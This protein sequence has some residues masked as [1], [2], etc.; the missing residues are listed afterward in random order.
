LT[1]SGGEAALECLEF[2]SDLVYEIERLL[3]NIVAMVNLTGEH[4]CMGSTDKLPFNASSNCIG[5]AEQVPNGR[6]TSDRTLVGTALKERLLVLVAHQ[7]DEMSCAG[8][9]QRS[10]DRIIAYATDGAPPD[11]YF[12]ASHGSRE[13]YAGVRRSEALDAT[14]KIGVSKLEFLDFADQLLYCALDAAFRAVSDIVQQYKPDAVLVPA[15]EGGH[16][17]HDSCSFLGS[18]LGRRLELRVWEMPLYHRSATGEL[19]CQEFRMLNGT[20]CVLLL[21]SKEQQTRNSMIASYASQMDLDDFVS[22]KAEVFRPQADYDYSRPAHE[23]L[24]NYEVWK[25]PISGTQ[26]CQAFIKCADSV[27]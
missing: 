26:V 4:Y 18:L 22:S 6:L 20:E 12:W 27:G 23:G 16:P 19:M 15:Y 13:G 1:L 17:D 14:A 9:L 8:L 11:R 7:D 5:D 24:L 10:S 21:S 25:W 2:I 3:S